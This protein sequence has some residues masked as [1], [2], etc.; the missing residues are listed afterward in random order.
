MAAPLEDF[1]RVLRAVYRFARTLSYTLIVLMVLFLVSQV[2]DIYR[3]LAD[4]HIALGIAFLV[5][6][7][8]AFGWFVGRPIAAFLRMPA[9]LKPPALPPLGERTARDLRRHLVFVERYLGSLLSN[10]EWEGAPEDVHAAMARCRALRD[11]TTDADSSRVSA[12]SGEIRTLE[13]E[14]VERLLAPLDRKARKIIRQ[15]ALGV[16]VATAV[17]WNGTI[18]AFVV[19]WRNANLCSRL[20]RVYYGRPGARGTLAILRDVSAATLA[21]AYLQ[22]L[23]EAAGSALSGIFGKTVGAFGGPLLDGGLNAVA[24]LRIGYVT[25]ARCR[26][27]SAWTEASRAQALKGAFVEAA[28]SSKEVVGEVIRTVGG[29]LWK[30]PATAISKLSEAVAGFFRKPGAGDAAPAGA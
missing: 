1:Q 3:L 5:V 15:E 21:S 7:L 19:L 9:V 12:L 6:F 25:K 28:T 27:F 8:A 11:S 2:V 10:P 30:I 16:G 23:S 18:D 24:T 20:A 22:D 4:I 14:T 26:A 17:S 13:R 29:G